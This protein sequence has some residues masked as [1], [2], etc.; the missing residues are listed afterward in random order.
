MV[1]KLMVADKTGFDLSALIFDVADFD[2]PFTRFS[3]GRNGSATLKVSKDITFEFMGNFNKQLTTGVAHTMLVKLDGETAL[4]I[5]EF[6]TS[7]GNLLLLGEAGGASAIM[8]AVSEKE[9]YVFGNK[10]DDTLFN[11]GPARYFGGAG[12]DIFLD[13]SGKTNHFDG[14][15]GIDSI[16]YS[17]DTAAQVGVTVNLADSSKN[18]GEAAGDTYRSIEGLQGSAF[19][20]VLVGTA[21]ANVLRGTDGQDILVGGGKGDRLDG[22]NGTDFA[23]YEGSLT[24]VTVHLA[25]TSRNTG[26]A[27][28]DTYSH[29][30]GLIGSA[31]DDDLTG[32]AADNTIKGGAGDDIIRHSGGNDILWGDSETFGVDGA[33]TFAFKTPGGG[34]VYIKDFDVSDHIQID[35][36]GF[37]LH[38]LWELS[39]GTTLIIAHSDPV[40]T[41]NSP[42]FLVEQFTGDLLFD[43]DGNGSGQAVLIANVLFHSQE[44]LDQNDFL[45]V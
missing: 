40:A 22:G 42:T 4:E 18:T 45:I 15:T 17:G 29:I 24:G 14:E 44:Y 30:E 21:R 26:E 3:S 35:R 9:N 34:A 36:T 23:S 37:G 33:D 38:A 6:N 11:L 27:N 28:G 12:N 2:T 5:K 8:L 43:A 20:D 7:L 41:T 19:D 31:H 13:T 1:L 32:D 10:G 16:L 25:L 39:L